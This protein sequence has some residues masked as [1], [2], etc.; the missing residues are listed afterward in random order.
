MPD[1]DLRVE[2]ARST[3][4][5]LFQMPSSPRS[6][7]LRLGRRLHL[8][9]FRSLS[10][11]Q[12]SSGRRGFESMTSMESNPAISRPTSFASADATETLPLPSLTAVAQAIAAKKRRQPAI[13]VD[14]DSADTLIPPASSAGVDI[15]VTPASL[16]QLRKSRVTRRAV[17]STDA[18]FIIPDS[19]ATGTRTDSASVQEQLSIFGRSVISADGTSLPR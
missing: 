1:S 8:M 15:T 2:I 14:L 13:I 3:A 5:P 6:E 9:L 18:S 12:R 7:Q 17:F 19:A 16:E 10:I 11:E 4:V